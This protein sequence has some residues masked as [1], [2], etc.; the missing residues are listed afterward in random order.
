M[1]WQVTQTGNMFTGTV[2]FSGYHGVGQMTVSGTMNGKTGTFTMT[3]PSGTMPMSG[4]T[5]QVTGTF[6]MDDMMALM[7]GSYTGAT[8]CFGAFD[9]GQMTMTLR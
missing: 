2:S 8:S 4:C 6:D 9:H 3:M 1:T 7:R 5:G